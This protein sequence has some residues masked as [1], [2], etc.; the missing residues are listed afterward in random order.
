MRPYRFAIDA[1]VVVWVAAM[2]ALGFLA[3]ETVD[4]IAGAAD[5]FSDI[6]RQERDLATALSPLE[7][8]PLAGAQVATADRELR[9]DS[10]RTAANAQLTGASIHE[11][12]RIVFALVVMLALFPVVTFYLPMRVA[13]SP[14]VA[15][16]ERRRPEP[17]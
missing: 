5:S 12:A 17:T 16:L 1:F 10:A 11:L 8:L 4:R 13:R 14:I 3:M 9:D 2:L 6:A 7:S 15:Q